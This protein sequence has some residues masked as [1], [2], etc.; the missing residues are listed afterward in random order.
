MKFCKLPLS[1]SEH[2]S[3][4]MV[5]IKKFSCT[6]RVSRVFVG[7]GANSIDCVDVRQLVL[8]TEEA[9]LIIM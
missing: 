7:T 1:N 3:D 9:T 6:K 8:Q 5:P 2:N 4:G